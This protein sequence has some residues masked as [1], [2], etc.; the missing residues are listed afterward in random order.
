[1]NTEY[2]DVYEAA[3]SVMLSI[4]NFP[5]LTESDAKD[6]ILEKERSSFLV[7]KAHFVRRLIPGYV[8]CLM[9]VPLSS[10]IILASVLILTVFFL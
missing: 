8:D 3:H 2:K 10:W 1:M 5:P 4:F 7:E 6:V 9:K